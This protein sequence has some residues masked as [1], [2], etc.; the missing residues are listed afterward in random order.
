MQISCAQ[1]KFMVR[2]HILE[3]KIIKTRDLTNFK[4]QLDKKVN[5]RIK[6]QFFKKMNDIDKP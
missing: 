1:G 4:N 3:E 2:L 6:S 5:K